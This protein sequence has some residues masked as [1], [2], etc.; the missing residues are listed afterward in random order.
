MFTKILIPTDGSTLGNL[1]ALEGLAM[2]QKVGA[3]VV[4]IYVSRELQNPLYDFS[5]FRP[6]N[7]PTKEEFNESVMAASENLM[8]PIKEAAETLGV[9]FSGITKISNATARSIVQAAEEHEC[10]L[11]FMGSHGCAGWG[12]NLLGS[13]ATKVLSTTQIPTLIYRLK[14]EPIPQQE[15]P[16]RYNSHLGI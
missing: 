5:E 14:Q 11:I 15:K 6:K 13:V 3:E 12:H 4:G 2:A 1:S 16:V 8:K 10:N 9:K 7:F